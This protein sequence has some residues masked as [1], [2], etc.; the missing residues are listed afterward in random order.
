MFGNLETTIQVPWGK[1]SHYINSHFEARS[2]WARGDKV[3]IWL[4]ILAYSI[5]FSVWATLI[6]LIIQ[7][8]KIRRIGVQKQ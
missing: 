3:P 6:Y 1:S 2:L 8:L 4:A 5:I 7:V